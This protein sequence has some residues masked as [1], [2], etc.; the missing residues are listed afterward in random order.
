MSPADLSIGRDPVFAD[1]VAEMRNKASAA[2]NY[3]GS[4][5][6]R[7]D[8]AR[9]LASIAPE[10]LTKWLQPGQQSYF[11][12]TSG[13]AFLESPTSLAGVEPEKQADYAAFVALHE[14]LHAL[15]TTD[16]GMA[17]AARRQSLVGEAAE[18]LETV[19]NRLEDARL[20]RLSVEADPSTEQ[21]LNDACDEIVRQ[22]RLAETSA[23]ARF[24]NALLERIYRGQADPPH[25]ARSPASPRSARA[26]R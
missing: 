17:Y 21:L 24:C 8:L 10:V 25:A 3:I 18:F 19:F 5:E 2:A 16:R 13:E 9:S 15:H 14:A 4:D 22:H 1:K 23:R 12:P 11:N 6:H 26:R 20:A 7:A